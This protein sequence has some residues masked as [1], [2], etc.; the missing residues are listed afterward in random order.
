MSYGRMKQEEERLRQEIADLLKQA[1]AADE[2]EDARYGADRSG[3]ELPDEL[4]RREERLKQIQDAKRRLEERQREADRD[5]LVI[6]ATHGARRLDHRAFATRRA[7]GAARSWCVIGRGV[8]KQEN[9][10]GRR[11]AR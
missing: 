11:P 9:P 4:R 10:G 8:E 1:E 5:V 7:P 6:P 3:D 2:A